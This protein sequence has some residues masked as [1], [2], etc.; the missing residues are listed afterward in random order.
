MTAKKIMQTI[1]F[2]PDVYA[3]IEKR[4]GKASFNQTINELLKQALQLSN[5]SELESKVADIEKR[6]AKLEKLVERG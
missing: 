6:L 1:Y 5:D 2:A 4:K 3:I